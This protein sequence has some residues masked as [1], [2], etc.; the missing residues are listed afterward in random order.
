MIILP[1]DGLSVSAVNYLR[2]EGFHV[3]DNKVAQEQLPQFINENKVEVLLV[4]SA[5]QV[6]KDLIDACPNLRIIGRAGV[7]MDNIDVEYAQKQGIQVINTPGASSKSVAEMVFTHARSLA[8]FL[9]DANRNMP[10]EGDSQ[11]KALKKSYSGATELAGKTMGVI[12]FG[13]IGQET[14]KLAIVNGMN[15]RVCDDHNPEPKLMTLE[16][17]DGQ[18]IDFQ[19]QPTSKEE[20]LKNAD[21]LSLHVPAQKEYVIAKEELDMM[22]PTAFLINTARGGL[23]NEADLIDALENDSIA[24]AGLDVFEEEPNPKIS[25]LMNPKLSLSPH[26]GGSTQEAQ[27][28][29]GFELADKIISLYRGENVQG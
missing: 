11:F 14:V 16:F 1:N 15:V 22:K 19:I 10:L 25:L 27:E 12:G 9:Y 29:I 23:V 8:R 13:R 4:R 26:V 20:V 18:E 17:F 2:E 24:G 21:Y 3:L 28:R 6:R 5:T 7:G